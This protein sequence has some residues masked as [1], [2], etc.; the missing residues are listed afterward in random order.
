MFNYFRRK[1]LKERCEAIFGVKLMESIHIQA[2]IFG[3]IVAVIGTAIVF[4][5]PYV[6][7]EETSEAFEAVIDNPTQIY[8]GDTIR[9]VRVKLLPIQREGASAGNGEIWPGLLLKDGYLYTVF[10]LRLAGIDTP[11]L[12]PSTRNPDG[13]RRSQASRDAEKTASKR[14][15]QALVDLLKTA[16]YN[17]SISYPEVGKYAGRLVAE[18]WVRTG[19]EKVNVSA[20][21]LK[22]KYAKSY[23]GG[24]K[25][26][27]DFGP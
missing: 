18:M 27:W 2:V 6:F 20:Y 13:S 5:L 16:D 1:A 14:A 8:D 12:R 15:R 19:E 26:S 4:G 11:E 7:G 17:V 22:N 24:K 9:D 23:D 25:P 10:D 3:V 21:M